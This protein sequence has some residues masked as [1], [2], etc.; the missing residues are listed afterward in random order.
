MPR[1]ITDA[2]GVTWSCIQAF[3]GLGN[4]PEKADAARVGS[5]R[6][7]FHV[8]CTPSGGAKSRCGS[9]SL[10]VGRRG[11]RTRRFWRPSARAS[12]EGHTLVADHVQGSPAVRPVNGSEPGVRSAAAGLGIGVAAEKRSVLSL[13]V[14]AHP[15]SK[16]TV[17][18]RDQLRWLAWSA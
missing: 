6:D 10:A 4:G 2:D 15:A 12:P 13:P 5:A 11:A 3:A 18:A 14:P 1:E 7:R 16:T 9:N 8:V 17:Y